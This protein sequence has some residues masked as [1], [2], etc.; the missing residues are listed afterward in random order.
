MAVN[1]ESYHQRHI[2]AVYLPLVNC[3]TS[4]NEIKPA[5]DIIARQ[6]AHRS[7]EGRAGH[8]DQSEQGRGTAFRSCG[9]VATT[10]QIVCGKWSEVV[11]R[12][13]AV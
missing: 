5:M 6:H 12:V 13:F 4:R 7:S 8:V 11:R 3:N 10:E 1:N 2:I 9:T